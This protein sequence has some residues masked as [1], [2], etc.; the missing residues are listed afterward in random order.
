MKKVFLPSLVFI[1]L[2]HIS[3]IAGKIVKVYEFNQPLVKQVGE[4]TL[5]SFDGTKLLGEPGKAILPF[6]PVRLLLP[7]GETASSITISYQN[8]V[9]A[10]G[11][12]LLMPFQGTSPLSSVNQPNWLED[13]SFYRSREGYPNTYETHLETQFYNGCGIAISVFTPVKYYPYK[14]QVTYFQ[15]VV[16]TIITIPDPE[17]TAHG[18]MFFPSGKKSEMLKQF[19]QNPENSTIYFS[20]K[21]FRS[22]QYDYLIITG[23]QFLTEFDTLINFYKPRGISAKAVSTTYISSDTTGADLQEKIRNYISGQY[24][25]Y[26]IDYVLL[27]GDVEIVPFRGFYCYADSEPDVEDYEIPSDLYYSALDGNWNTD[28]DNRWAEPDEDDLYPEIAIGRLTFSDTA[29]LHNM[30]HKILKFQSDPVLGELTSPLLSGEYLYN[31]PLTYGSTYMNLLV[32]Y[33]TDNGYNTHGIPPG[34]P[35]DTLYD[36]PGYSFTKAQLIS[37]INAGHPLVHHTGHANYNTVMRMGMGDI[38]NTNFSQTNGENHNY[39]VIYTHGCICGGFDYSDCIAEKMIT[40]DNMAVAFVGNSRYGWF[41]QGT[42]DGPSEH[43]H[44]EFVDALYYDSLYR[45]GMAHL[46]SKSETAPFVEVSGEFEPGATRWCFY[47][48][49]VL[50]DPVMALWTQEPYLLEADFPGMVPAGADTIRVHLSGTQGICNHFTCS[51]Y[52]NDTLFGSG[53]TNS[54]GIAT[55]QMSENLT[56]GPVSLVV[57]GYNILPQYFTIEVSDYWLGHS[58]QWDDPLNWYSGSLPDSSTYLIVPASPVGGNFPSK[59]VSGN[60]Q[61]KAIY[62][63]PGAQLILGNGETFNI[64]GD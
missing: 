6:Y 49:N 59:N 8:P 12:F 64:S 36:K 10:E 20:G 22:N 9:K 23:N 31:N 1:L 21:H 61:C 28:G 15:R 55:I 13:K 41:N 51:I 29:E 35:R 39:T 37:K 30:I 43:L 32:G 34:H 60:R 38:T 54:A 46:K 52:R 47:D 44:R 24:Q 56:F 53:L 50:G 45:I 40:I 18:S 19:V 58:D 4:Y 48:N 26:G 63:E 33:H 62:I 5:I 7:P 11:R 57:S 17:A 25:N 3:L 27:G 42:S 14:K 16:V 2:F